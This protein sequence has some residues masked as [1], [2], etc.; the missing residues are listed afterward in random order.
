MKP[1]L[2]RG[3]LQCCGA[4]TFDEYRQSIEKDAALSRRFQPV[5]V[6]EPSPSSTLSI[7]RGLRTRYEVHH[8]VGIK[9]EALVTAASYAARYLPER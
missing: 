3:G 4:T 7:L 2:A 8:G 5:I 6:R 9:D 1:L